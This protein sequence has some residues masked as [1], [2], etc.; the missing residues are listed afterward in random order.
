MEHIIDYFSVE[1]E[2][3]ND[4]EKFGVPILK[5]GLRTLTLKSKYGDILFYGTAPTMAELLARL[6]LSLLQEIQERGLGI[7]EAANETP[8]QRLRLA[9]K[10][11]EQALN[12]VATVNHV[13][14]DL[15]NIRKM[16][17]RE[18]RYAY[19]VRIEN[20]TTEQVYP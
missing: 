8:I 6:P 13:S 15:I 19:V 1:T 12:A 17:D 9:S 7:T 11:F 20:T 14:V 3:R 10:E 4:L 18:D 16:E 5:P 2:P